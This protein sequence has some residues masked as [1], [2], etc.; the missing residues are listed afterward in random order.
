M[1]IVI[2]NNRDA[3]GREAV[4]DNETKAEGNF[5]CSRCGKTGRFITYVENGIPKGPGG[6]CFRCGGKG[7][8]NQADRKRNW[9]YDNHSFAQGWGR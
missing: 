9:G 6:Q 1:S 7:Y 3:K 4:W 8:H 5:A 2:D